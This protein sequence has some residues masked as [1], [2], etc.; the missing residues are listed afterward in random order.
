MKDMKIHEGCGV[1][2]PA[3]PGPRDRRDVTHEHTAWKK[4]SGVFL[5]AAGKKTPDVFSSPGCV[6]A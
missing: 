6:R 5:A 4:T 3:L 1:G 2:G